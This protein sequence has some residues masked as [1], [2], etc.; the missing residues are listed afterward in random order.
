M[1]LKSISPD[2]VVLSPEL[3]RSRGSKP[4]EDRL[5]ASIDEI[6]LAE[7]IKVAQMPD[8]RYLVVD[9]HMRLRAISAIRKSHPDRFSSIPAYLVD[10]EHR[11]ELRFQT[12]IY[13][14]LLPSQLAG[15]VEH[16]HKT[17]HVRK[18]DIG[19]Y[20]GVSP[21]TVR[22][23]TGL[24]R[25]LQRGGLFE[26]LVEMMDVGVIPASNPY[27]WLRLNSK[28]IRY[29][30][31]TS[32]SDGEDAEP[33]LDTQ[34]LGAR[35]GVVARYPIKFVESATSGL[36]AEFYNADERVRLQKR[37]LGL[38]RST[39][40]RNLA[41]ASSAKAIE[42]LN[43]VSKESPEPVIRSAALALAGYLQ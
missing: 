34:V 29:V 31:E 19:R 10:F 6:G 39:P 3:S 11:Y 33:W 13:Q 21:P 23:Y 42:H 35:R 25:M 16:L 14:D 28:G 30:L 26:R 17:E 4:F 2:D 36:R 43:R 15:L 18:S 20:I 38:R 27:A 32:F 40:A 24:W 9:G 5:R 22:N 37:D 41:K 12:D 1:I 8:E 7:P